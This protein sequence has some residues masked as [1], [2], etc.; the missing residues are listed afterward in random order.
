MKCL[1]ER[2]VVGGVAAVEAGAR[3]RSWGE[4]AAS[5][6]LGSWLRRTLRS[7]GLLG[8]VLLRSVRLLRV[9]SLLRIT[10]LR[11]ALLHAAWLIGARGVATYVGIPT[12]VEFTTLYVD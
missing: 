5:E 4:L 9:T 12:L 11:V 8:S 7:I 1:S 2:E 3:S 6:R 10:L